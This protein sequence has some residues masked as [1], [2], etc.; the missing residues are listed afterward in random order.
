MPTA[1]SLPCPGSHPSLE[2]SCCSA[3][4]SQVLDG[5]RAFLHVRKWGPGCML[6]PARR[7]DGT[8]AFPHVRKWGP[9]GMLSPARRSGCS[10]EPDQPLS[11]G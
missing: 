1:L 10:R 6:S 5:A 2:C 4:P 3:Q 11:H 9:E 8:H 7:W